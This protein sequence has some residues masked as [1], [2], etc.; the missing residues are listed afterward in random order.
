MSQPVWW[1]RLSLDEQRQYLLEHPNSQLTLQ[2][3]PFPPE[4]LREIE[5][6]LGSQD[7][8]DELTPTVDAARTRLND[9]V[10]DADKDSLGTTIRR[11]WSSKSAVA[12]RRAVTQFALKAGLILLTSA[13]L[14]VTTGLPTSFYV[15]MLV[16]F[17]WN[18]LPDIRDPRE[19]FNHFGSMF[20]DGL[21]QG[22]LHKVLLGQSLRRE[23]NAP[24]VRKE[25][26]VAIRSNHETDL[27][28]TL[29]RL[30]V[31]YTAP[32]TSTSRSVE[33]ARTLTRIAWLEQNIPV[34]GNVVVIASPQRLSLGNRANRLLSACTT[35]LSACYARAT[36]LSTGTVNRALQTVF[37]QHMRSAP[38]VARTTIACDSAGR[39]VEFSA[40]EFAHPRGRVAL[41]G[42]R[43]GDVVE[44]AYSV[45]SLFAPRHFYRMRSRDLKGWLRNNI[46]VAP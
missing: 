11:A 33:I 38:L 14:T 29:T 34:L 25:T 43:D 24:S 20:F 3:Q 6:A 7:L 23:E 1:T 17:N 35:E 30:E 10:S 37:K 9:T 15:P 21:K 39:A 36:T 44:L 12:R 18:D 5:S 42:R 2:G 32:P 28:K 41:L 45:D 40:F 22:L 8:A 16:S 46:E 19:M 31:A 13:T 27:N 4:A 26:A